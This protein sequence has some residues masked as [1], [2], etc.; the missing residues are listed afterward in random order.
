LAGAKALDFLVI[1]KIQG[2]FF[3]NTSTP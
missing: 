2:F 1:R 3:L